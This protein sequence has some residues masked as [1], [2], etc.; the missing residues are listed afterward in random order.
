MPT[1]TAVAFLRGEVGASSMMAR[2]IQFKFLYLRHATKNLNNTLLRDTVNEE[3]KIPVGL[4]QFTNIWNA[5][6][7]RYSL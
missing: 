3:I 6:V 7:S 1:Y 4:R 5:V 2:D